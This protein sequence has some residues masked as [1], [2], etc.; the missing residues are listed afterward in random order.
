MNVVVLGYY[1]E[2]YAH[3]GMMHIT[4]VPERFVAA[5]EQGVTIYRIFSVTPYCYPSYSCFLYTFFCPRISANNALAILS[6]RCGVV[7]HL[8]YQ[9]LKL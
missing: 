5:Y 6:P 8:K 4:S 7:N 2:F 1:A 9:A 3:D